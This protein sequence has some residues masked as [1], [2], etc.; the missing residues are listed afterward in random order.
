MEQ[1]VMSRRAFA[2]GASAAGLAA[3]LA[4]AMGVKPQRAFAEAAKGNAANEGAFGE[5]FGHCRMCM[6][7]GS[8]SFIGT[9]K[10]GVVVNIEGDPK[11]M[12]NAGGLCPRGKSA[13]MNLY[14]PYRLKAPMKRTNPEKGM[15]V[16]PGWVEITWDEAL[17]ATAAAIG[18][19]LATDPRT[20]VH[21]YS[22][23]A[24]E[25]SH[26]TMG[27]GTWGHI[28]GT[29]N[30]TAVKGQMCAIH[31][32]GMYT[33]SAAPTVNYD[34]KYDEYV[35]V[36]GKSLGYDN[37]YGGGDARTFANV[38]RRGGKFV[39]VGPR[40]TMEASRGEWV[41]CKPATELAL[42]YAWLHE[43]LWELDPGIDVPFVKNRTNSPY[44]IGPDGLYITDEEGKPYLWDLADGQAKV[45]DDPTLE[46]PALEGS[47]EVNGVTGVPGLELVKNAV[48][49]CT[50]EWASE[51][52]TVPASTIKRIIAELV[53]HSH[54]G[55]TITIDGVEMPFRPAC[56]VI[57]RGCTNQQV[58][59]LIDI[60]SREINILLGNAG[61]P[62]GIMSTMR[63]DYF[64]NPV[65]GTI[66]PFGEA[67]T[68]AAP[69]T[70]PP[71]ALDYSDYFPHKHSTQTF[72]WHTLADPQRYGI[73]YTP[74]V[75]VSSAANPI[76]GSDDAELVIEGLKKFETVIYQACYHMDEM[77]MMS[78][79]LLPEH[80]ALEQHTC[81]HFPGN[82]CSSTA[83]EE[84]FEE[85]DHMV[86]VRK[87]IKP[88][89]NTMDGNDQLIEIFD[90]MGMLQVWNGM[91]DMLG[92]IG[93][94]IFNSINM[95]PAG[96]V[97]FK[98]PRFMLD[99][100][101]KYTAEEMFDLNLKSQFGEDKGLD[102]L[103][104]ERMI[105]FSIV[106]GKDNYT[107]YRNSS[108][109]F[110]VYLES[111][112]R[113]GRVLV[114]A[115]REFPVDM[116]DILG[117]D[118]D[119]LERRFQPIPHFPEAKH[120]VIENEPAEFDLRAVIYRQPLFMFRM[121]SMDQDP[122]RR[123]YADRY[124][125][126]SN[127]VLIHPDSAAAKGIADG[128]R[129]LVSSPYGHTEATARLTQTIRPDSVAIG[130]MRGR[131]TS[132]MGEALLH[133]A[134]SNELLSGDFGHTD[135]LDAAEI[136]Q[137]NVKIEKL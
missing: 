10:D 66:E 3:A 132:R 67:A 137:V 83:E 19:C 128:D 82:E 86:V 95:F 113:S 47:F 115:L 36:M 57:G 90:R 129:V 30:V 26:A 41:S 65:N 89:Y 17:N 22:F 85:A 130:G 13:I 62:G 2:V 88:M 33:M 127:S 121:A 80:A 21:L 8:C 11:R 28:L 116:G 61:Y 37:G 77:A 54:F 104:K 35:V 118:L 69:P 78:D 133:D 114:P 87:G 64:V 112:L 93:F 79:Y 40:A 134:N 74:R 25:S 42:V 24:Y 122:I 76:V 16:D 55:S 70:W 96:G 73:D 109:R 46:D 136:I 32:G 27:Q 49:D 29:P 60:W 126:D 48:K 94:V 111:Q 6:L 18:G 97:P 45:F 59:T 15:E 125:P 58:G 124:L 44:L 84:G 31:Y 100:N 98:D 99:L 38:V 63:T 71:Q 23:A 102:Y 107:S 110:Q 123:D 105:P 50:A 72:M 75:M 39:V 7:C 81:H 91:I 135:P 14:N 106:R 5:V 4:K 131:K 12:T 20:L 68:M 103:D 43:M 52:T 92:A 120:L 117:I 108:V 51:L 119:E 34:G 1:S 53:E 9:V 101:T 56:L